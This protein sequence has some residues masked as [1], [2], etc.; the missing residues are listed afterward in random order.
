VSPADEGAPF[1]PVGSVFDE[2]PSLNPRIA[3][4]VSR[5]L[6][7]YPSDWRA[8]YGDEFEAVLASSMS[9]GKGGLRLSL[10]V[11]REGMAARLE[12]A[13]FVGRTAPPLER[14]RA[15]VMTVFAATL[16]F[17]ASAVVLTFYSKGW[18]RTPVLETIQRASA[19]FSRSKAARIDKKAMTSPTYRRLLTAAGRTNNGNSAAWKT[20]RTFQTNAQTAA[21][22]SV[23]GRALHL[24]ISHEHPASGAPVLFNDIAQIATIAA[25][26][27]LVL[28]L[29]L[30]VAAAVRVLSRANRSRLLV[31]LSF[32]C[33]SAA[34]FVIGAI[35]Y[36]AFQRIPPGEPSVWWTVQALFD[37][38]FRFWPV[39][40]FPLCA[41]ASIAL[42]VVGGMRLMQRVDFAP[43][44][45]R[46]QG[47]LAVVAA[48]CLGVVFVATLTWVATLCVQAPEFL[49]AKDGGVVGTS[50]LPVFLVAMIVMIGALWLVVKGSARCLRSV[51]AA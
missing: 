42:A 23:A 50:F 51:R 46:L 11:A 18:Q 1:E 45:Y 35:A 30:V 29:T 8:R 13:G 40:V 7:W 16:G 5:L 36:H 37:G 20:F 38:N 3:A 2:E 43:R 10:D 4:R 15:S 9:D 24:A 31:P 34:F 44:T 28:A 47:S 21:N 26:A 32:L 48:G 12:S 22:N 33:T 25:I 14:A 41:A 27:L 6:R 49:T 39:V 19:V 17:F